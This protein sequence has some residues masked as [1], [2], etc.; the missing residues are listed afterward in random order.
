MEINNMLLREAKNI[1]SR[2]GYTV[3]AEKSKYDGI[4]NSTP[5][6]EELISKLKTSKI[7]AD[8]DKAEALEEKL[9]NLT[10]DNLEEMQKIKKWKAEW[11]AKEKTMAGVLDD[12]AKFLGD[13]LDADG[14]LFFKVSGKENKA[15]ILLEKVVTVTSQEDVEAMMLKVMQKPDVVS[16]ASD[17]AAEMANDFKNL[18]QSYYKRALDAGWVKLGDVKTSWK[19]TYY[20]QDDEGKMTKFIG[21]KAQEAD[22]AEWAEKSRDALKR[23][24]MGESYRINEGVFGDIWA[25][26]KSFGS[27]L[28]DSIFG[29]FKQVRKETR[30]ALKNYSLFLDAIID[31]CELKLAEVE[32]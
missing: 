16:D 26:I 22:R 12:S 21:K 17:L 23:K 27:W 8:L 14:A 31:A 32:E 15:G 18:L 1:L 10:E 29:E 25:K 2:C 19:A 3:L 24:K 11:S 28:Y 30:S 7:Q 13:A 6:V 5:D 4:K 9:K 20:D